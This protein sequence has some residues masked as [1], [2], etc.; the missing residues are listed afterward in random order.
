M[1]CCTLLL[2]SILPCIHHVCRYFAITKGCYEGGDLPPEIC[3]A[4]RLESLILEGVSAGSECNT[5]FWDPLSL[6]NSAYVGYNDPGTIP[7]CVWDMP[8]LKTLH[9]SGNALTGSL[10]ADQS[11]SFSS[12]SDSTT[13]TITGT[14]TGSR[15]AL[16]SLQ[17][18]SLSFNQLTG[19]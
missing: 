5:P 10:P 17:D 6:L 11:F 16:L 4:S 9:L 2:L 14:I 18:I 19:R 7:S 12:S 8:R 13:T 15:A 3:L 1:L